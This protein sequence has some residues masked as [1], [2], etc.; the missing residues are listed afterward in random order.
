MKTVFVDIDTQLDFLFPAGALYVPGAESLT[1]S[2]KQLTDFAASNAIQIVSTADAHTEDDPEFTVW[3][4]HCVAG[5]ASQQKAAATLLNNRVVLA[6][7]AAALDE[8]R[9][10]VPDAAQIVVEKQKLDCFTN[11]H[12]GPLLSMLGGERYIVYGLVTEY[13]VR[14]AALGLLETG[15]QVE[16]VIDAARS[17][18]SRA[19]EEAIDQ[20]RQRGG[21]LTTLQE[22]TG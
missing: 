17:L 8:I 16:L 20:F 13:C 14:Y 1:A 15:A 3:K 18:D 9:L 4:P 22:V 6:T 12:L 19:G 7:T 10:R 21:L 11:P 2:L 5:T